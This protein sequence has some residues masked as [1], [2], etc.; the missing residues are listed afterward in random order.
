MCHRMV[1]GIVTLSLLTPVVADDADA[2]LSQARQDV[3]SGAESLETLVARERVAE[4]ELKVGAARLG[5]LK[6]QSCLAANRPADAVAVARAARG[7]IAAV[8]DAAVR[9]AL[10]A[11]L[12]AVTQTA[13]A[14]LSQ[15]SAT[16]GPVLAADFADDQAA[17]ESTEI[18]IVDEDGESGFD[19][20]YYK[21][22]ETLRLT[23]PAER[24][25]EV[26]AY[27]DQALSRLGED[28]DIYHK[29]MIYPDDFDVISAR[30]AAFSDGVIY[31]GPGFANSAGE[32]VS[33]V[34][35]DVGDLIAPLPSFNNAPVFDLNEIIQTGL[36][37]AALRQS[38]EIFN[39]YAEDLAAGLPLLQYF[40]G[41]DE[42][43][44]APGGST[45]EFED[46]MRMVDR[47]LQS[48]R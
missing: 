25:M 21:V 18:I 7:V 20:A 24:D 30:R 48:G 32:T 2:L 43:H 1:A 33:T 46:L 47:V 22:R 41:V 35:Y 16:P 15:G 12:D 23:D 31:R 4:A 3:T 28:P 37:R 39:G 44:A 36:D 38:S 9:S 5:V 8:Q 17:A 45:R 34:I 40:G 6:A 42:S 14:R 19:R 29:V 27:Q 10:S 13:E 11:E 26:Q